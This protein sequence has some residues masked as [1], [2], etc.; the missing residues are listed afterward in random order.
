MSKAVIKSKSKVSH[1]DERKVP[2]LIGEQYWHIS[3]S[4][5]T[6]QVLN[7]PSGSPALRIY[8]SS[9]GN[10][11]NTLLI[12]TDKKSLRELGKMLTKCSTK[13]SDKNYCCKARLLQQ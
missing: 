8:T 9:F 1:L 11:E 3:N 12:F 13:C 10:L 6:F 2:H 5:I 7:H 4:G